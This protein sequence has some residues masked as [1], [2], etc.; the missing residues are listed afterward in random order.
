VARIVI[1]FLGFPLMLFALLAY[2]FAYA[3]NKENRDYPNKGFWYN[4]NASMNLV[5]ETWADEIC[6]D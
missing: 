2:P 4:Y 3:A 1:F 6:K 5:Y